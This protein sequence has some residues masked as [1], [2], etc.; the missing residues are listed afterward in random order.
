M[1]NYDKE[2]P[3]GI[4]FNLR[5]IEDMNLIKMDM[6]KKLI[7]NGEIGTVRIGAKLHIARA[8]LI[9]YLENNTTEVRDK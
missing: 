5:E 6:A 4:L 1:I 7:M 9:Q 2:I 8:I 3:Y